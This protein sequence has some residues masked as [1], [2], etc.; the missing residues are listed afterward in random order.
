MDV[1]GMAEPWGT[2]DERDRAAVR[3]GMLKRT[4]Y[5][6]AA[7]NCALLLLY[8]ISSGMS[9]KSVREPFFEQASDV[10]ASMRTRTTGLA[11]VPPSRLLDLARMIARWRRE[12]YPLHS[13]AIDDI[14]GDGSAEHGA[15]QWSIYARLLLKLLRVQSRWRPRLGRGWSR[16][17]RQ[18]CRPVHRRLRFDARACCWECA[19]RIAQPWKRLRCA[20]RKVRCRTCGTGA[21]QRDGFHLSS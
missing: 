16:A 21:R 12:R 4:R 15:W 13:A 14:L 7:A 3:S 5:A 6:Q 11:E 10:G 19:A 8:C 1:E 20:C 2:A 9:A 18:D 17:L